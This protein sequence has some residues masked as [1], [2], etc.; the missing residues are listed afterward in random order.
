MSFHISLILILYS[1]STFLDKLLAS[2][3]VF[4]FVS[5]VI[6]SKL[7]F[8]RSFTLNVV[9]LLDEIHNNLWCFICYHKIVHIRT[10]VLIVVSRL[11]QIDPSVSVKSSGSESD[12]S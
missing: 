7:V 9:L 1:T 12:G 4:F 6:V 5:F 3:G 11:V 8:W 2:N 10:D